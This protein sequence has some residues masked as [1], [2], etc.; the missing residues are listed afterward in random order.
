MIIV[1][2]IF[3]FCKFKKFVWFI[4]GIVVFFIIVKKCDDF[5]NIVDVVFVV[6]KNDVV[7][8]GYD[9]DDSL[10]EVDDDLR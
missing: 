2:Y 8:L 10:E 9:F 5:D 7:V 3:E 6:V 4:V 1:G